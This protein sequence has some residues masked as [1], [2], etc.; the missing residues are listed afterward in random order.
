LHGFF[1][2]FWILER[3]QRNTEG[4]GRFKL[5]V[6]LDGTLQGVNSVAV[7]AL[8]HPGLALNIESTGAFGIEEKGLGSFDER[9]IGPIVVEIGDG[10][11]YVSLCSIL[12]GERTLVELGCRGKALSATR[13]FPNL[14][15]A[16]ARTR[17]LARPTAT[18]SPA[19]R[20]AAAACRRSCNSSIAGA[21]LADRR[22]VV[23]QRQRGLSTEKLLGRAVQEKGKDN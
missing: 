7:I 15:N 23:E 21:A 12:P 18:G 6:K 3:E 19:S 9:I 22:P 14:R 4:I 16:S 20:A 2:A 11:A 17:K 13:T 1:L 5:R 8:F 10:E